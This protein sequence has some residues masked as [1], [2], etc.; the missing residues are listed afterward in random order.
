MPTRP[1]LRTLVP[2]ALALALLAACSGAPDT[3]PLGAG[4]SAIAE[5]PTADDLAIAVDAIRARIIEQVPVDALEAL[6]AE[7]AL[8]LATDEEREVLSTGFLRFSVDAPATIHVLLSPDSDLVPFWLEER[9]FAPSGQD[10]LVDGDDDFRGWSMQVPAGE[11]ALGVPSI[12]AAVKPYFVVVAPAAEGDAQ[13]QISALWPDTMGVAAA[14]AGTRVFTDD[15]DELNAI[16]P[17]LAGLPLLQTLEKR[18]NESALLGYFRATPYPAGADAD[19]VVLTW[20]GDT[21]TTQSIQW[22]TATD[23][24]QSQLRYVADEAGAEAVV[25]EAQSVELHTPDVANDPRVMRHTVALEGLQPGT[26]YRYAIGDGEQWGEERS[27]NTGPSQGEP[28]SF[29]YM[30]DAQ[31]GLDGWGELVRKAH[32]ETPQAAFY[33]MAGDLVNWGERRDDWDW[34]FHNA[35]GVYDNRP[36]VPAIGNHEVDQGRAELY[37]DQFDLPRNGPEGIEPER[38]YSLEYADTLFVVLDSNLEPESQVEWLDAT[39]DASDATWKFAVFHHPLYSPRP[40]DRGQPEQKAA[41][42]PVFEKHGVDLVLQGDDHAYLRTFP[43]R[44]DEVVDSPAEGPVYIM[45]VAGSKMYKQTDAPYVARRFT[46]IA[47]YQVIDIDGGTLE[48]R[49]YDV[50]GALMDEFTIQK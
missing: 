37:V 39:L 44:G 25:V 40:G 28:F 15:T 8:A 33:V 13:P 21:A 38:V 35:R 36:L 32:A 1:S 24:G 41:W 47:T 18:E 26:R 11:V 19:H 17:A 48:Y 30:G 29:I 31:T 23:S 50:A 7:Q 42:A 6:P 4:A 9:G 14:T 34:L 22:R 27:F 2:G 12:E 45:S 5:A 20:A 10:A 3:A 49:S 16:D 43:M 46:D